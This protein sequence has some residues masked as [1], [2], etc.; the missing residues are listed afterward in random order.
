MDRVGAHEALALDP[1]PKVIWMQLSVRNDA[2]AAPDASAAP[3]G[4]QSQVRAA[5]LLF[6][7]RVCARLT[8]ACAAACAHTHTHTKKNVPL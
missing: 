1:L 5:L 4:M 2:A 6:C 3:Q 7:A 8:A